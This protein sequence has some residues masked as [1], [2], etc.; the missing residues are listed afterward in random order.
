MNAIDHLRG[1]IYRL[2][3]V[4]AFAGLA[5]PVVA[6]TLI[7]RQQAELNKLLPIWNTPRIP[8]GMQSGP[9]REASLRDSG[10]QVLSL[11]AH[12]VNFAVTGDIGFYVDELAA[13]LEPIKPGEP[14]QF[15]DPRTFTIRVHRGEVIVPPKALTAL[16]N[17]HI[18]EYSPRPLNDMQVSTDDGALSAKGG[19]KLWS[20]FPG[21]WLGA[22]MTGPI[23]LNDS[24]ELIFTPEDVRL[25]NIPLGGLLRTLGIKLSWLLS[26]DREGAAL[27]DSHLVLNHRKV[28]P[29]PALAGNIASVSMS[30]AGLHLSFADNK[31]AK[32]V[33]PPEHSKSYLWVQSGD[34]KL[35]DVIATNA[36]VMI[37][38]EKKD[39]VLLFD[40]YGYRK[41]V[42]AGKLY[43]D[44]TGTIIARVPS[45]N[46][47]PQAAI[48][49]P[50]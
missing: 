48:D 19:L 5:L 7:E 44:Q 22:K 8:A 13:S 14:V 10:A 32:F 46:R 42:N 45:Y 26:L 11:R 33:A 37:M 15:D 43:M 28:F 9:L 40:L 50:Q 12:N 16:F 3:L 39:E 20:W 31:A 4:A 25:F 36:N 41:Q 47:L 23:T 34:A 35:F 30:K 6:A 21:F 1:R 24:N 17:Q 38:D 2:A 18:L 49:K 29:P 27:V